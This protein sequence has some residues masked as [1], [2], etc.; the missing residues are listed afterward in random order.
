MLLSVI[1]PVYNEAGTIRDILA[2]VVAAPYEKELLVVDDAS[3]DGTREILR[4]MDG[5]DGI[6]LL[7]QDRRRGK[8]AAL[9]RAL[10]KTRGDWVIFQDA[11]L[12]YPPKNY[13]V[14]LE[15]LLE[16]GADAVYGSRFL[17]SHRV[18]LFWHYAANRF[19]TLITNVLFDTNLT[20][21]ETG[22]K[23]FRGDVIRTLRLR[24]EAFDIEPEVTARLFQRGYRVFEVP[25]L[26]RGRGYSEGKKVGWRDGV[27]A[28]WRLL[29]CRLTRP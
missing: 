12:E 19:L 20:D 8:G 1:I 23:A 4:E 9:R 28:L 5:K 2:K 17:G 29:C 3:D 21:M 26:Y 18:F 11:D 15:P 14:L 6:R 27:A 22:A 13:S 25:I 24:A 10:P 16:H 7:V